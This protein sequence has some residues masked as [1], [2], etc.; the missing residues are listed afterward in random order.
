[1]V[2]APA[3]PSSTRLSAMRPTPPLSE[4]RHSDN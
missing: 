2:A 1:L 3:E 4:K